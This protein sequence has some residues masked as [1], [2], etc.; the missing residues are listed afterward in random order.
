MIKFVA[1]I[2]KIAVM[3]AMAGQL[4]TMVLVM[5]GNAASAQKNMITYSK[6]T[7]ALTSD[8]TS[9][10]KVRQRFKLLQLTPCKLLLGFPE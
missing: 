3:L 1:A 2:I 6:L 7:R 10:K 9:R 4:K 5:A 8:G